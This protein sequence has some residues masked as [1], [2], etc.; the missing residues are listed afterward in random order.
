MAS[1]L[2]QLKQE[3]QKQGLKSHEIQ[4]FIEQYEAAADEAAQRLRDRQKF[5]L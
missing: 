4:R 3:L 5:G 1:P 2:E